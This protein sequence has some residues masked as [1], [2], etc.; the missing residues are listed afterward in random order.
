MNCDKQTVLIHLQEVG[1]WKA[2]VLSVANKK[3]RCTFPGNLPAKHH[4]TCGHKQ[5]FLYRIVT[6]NEKWRHSANCEQR[7]EW[8]N[9]SS[10]KN[11]ILEE[12]RCVSAGTKKAQF[13][14]NS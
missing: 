3:Q 13:T 1:S 4:S 10:K 12:S 6:G 11:F 2:H 7:K 5:R 8:L 9:G 14:G